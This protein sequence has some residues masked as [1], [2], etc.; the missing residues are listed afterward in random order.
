MRGRGQEVGG[1]AS[2]FRYLP[3]SSAIPLIPVS[4]RGAPTCISH[5]SAAAASESANASSRNLRTK[6]SREGFARTEDG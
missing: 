4:G 6:F 3:P 1:G 2:V 5:A